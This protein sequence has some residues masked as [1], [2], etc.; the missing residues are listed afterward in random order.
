MAASPLLFNIWLVIVS[1]GWFSLQNMSRVQWLFTDFTVPICSLTPPSSG[2]LQSLQIG[3]PAAIVT[4]PPI[5]MLFLQPEWNSATH[6]TSLPKVFYC[7]P[8][9]LGSWSLLILRLFIHSKWPPCISWFRVTSGPLD[10][11]LSLPEIFFHMHNR[12]F[13]LLQVTLPKCSFLLEPFP[14]HS[15]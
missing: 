6:V 1:F 10:L 2:L 5:P 13:H 8:H 11:L 15:V 7:A 3:L 9:P 4:F 12:Y 14:A